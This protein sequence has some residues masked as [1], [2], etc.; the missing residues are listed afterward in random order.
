MG[1]D[2]W[3]DVSMFSDGVGNDELVSCCALSSAEISFFV[4]LEMIRVLSL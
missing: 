3:K 4:V 2:S 1:S